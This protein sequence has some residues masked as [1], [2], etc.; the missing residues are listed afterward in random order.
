M[1]PLA[2]VDLQAPYY[3]IWILEI[4]KILSKTK[5]LIFLRLK[6]GLILVLA[7]GRRRRLVGPLERRLEAPNSSEARL[8]AAKPLGT[9]S[10][11]SKRF[12]SRSVLA[13]A[14]SSVAPNDPDVVPTDPDVAR[15]DL[16]GVQTNLDVAQIDPVFGPRPGIPQLSGGE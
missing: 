2:A 13:A 12:L 7:P 6:S 15:I 10:E 16:D 1:A 11:R 14:E 8:G 3:L 4:L 9:P 5:V